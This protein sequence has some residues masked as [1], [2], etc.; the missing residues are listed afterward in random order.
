MD[1]MFALHMRTVGKLV[2][3]YGQLRLQNKWPR[4]ASGPR[5]YVLLLRNVVKGGTMVCC[6]DQ[7]GGGGGVFDGES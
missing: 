5:N 1:S 3:T 7:G 4:G 6:F 2:L